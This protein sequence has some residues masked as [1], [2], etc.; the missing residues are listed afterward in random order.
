MSDEI[1]RT[2][3]QQS[4]DRPDHKHQSLTKFP[5]NSLYIIFKPVGQKKDN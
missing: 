2:I 3:G 4:D 5:D 1:D